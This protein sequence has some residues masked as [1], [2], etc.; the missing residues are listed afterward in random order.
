MIENYIENFLTIKCVDVQ[1]INACK[2]WRE[3]WAELR[4]MVFQ[5]E[6]GDLLTP[7]SLMVLHP[8]SHSR[9]NCIPQL[10]QTPNL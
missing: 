1:G 9:C 2:L 7:D 8:C 3:V 4:D 10:L 5:T 6:S